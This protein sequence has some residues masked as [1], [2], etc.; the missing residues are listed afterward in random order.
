MVVVQG[1][2]GG[3]ADASERVRVVR[4]WMGWDVFVDCLV[5]TRERLRADIPAIHLVSFL[6]LRGSPPRKADTSTARLDLDADVDG[7]GLL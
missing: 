3:S 6:S 7:W 5:E 4:D 2:C 1:V